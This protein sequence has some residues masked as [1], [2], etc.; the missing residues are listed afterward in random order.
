MALKFMDKIRESLKEDE[1]KTGSNR[2]AG[3]EGF[4]GR[5]IGSSPVSWGLLLLGAFGVYA[6][7]NIVTVIMKI[8]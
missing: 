8:F 4:F 7:I 1:S 3:I 6:V 5:S 2:F